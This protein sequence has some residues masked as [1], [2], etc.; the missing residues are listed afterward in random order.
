MEVL[1]RDAASVDTK[2]LNVQ[3]WGQI[4]PDRDISSHDNMFLTI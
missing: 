3:T 4:N 1:D 2:K